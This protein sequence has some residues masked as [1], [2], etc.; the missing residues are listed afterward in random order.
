MVFESEHVSKSFNGREVVR[1]FST[2]IMRGDRV[3]LIG[4]YGA[5]K[6]TLPRLLLGTLPPDS[7]VIRQG[8]NVQVAYYDQ[9]REQLDPERT[10]FD[11]VGDGSDTVTVNGQSRHVNG[12]LRDFLFA[13]KRA[14]S[15]VKALSGGELNRLMLARL[16]IR[17]ANVLVLDEPINDLDLDSSSTKSATR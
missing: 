13:P 8:V 14:R 5:G 17:P 9:Q 3:E 16:F 12:Y 4:P 1:E 6:T 11:T 2:R 7:G 15:P 10:V